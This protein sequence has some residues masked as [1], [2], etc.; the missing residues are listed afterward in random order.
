MANNKELKMAEDEQ[1]TLLLQ[2]VKQAIK[3]MNPKV[4]GPGEI[5]GGFPVFQ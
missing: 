4:S 3:K 1:V 2:A 5:P